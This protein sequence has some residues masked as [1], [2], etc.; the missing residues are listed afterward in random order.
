MKAPWPIAISLTKGIPMYVLLGSNGNI[1]SKAAALLLAHGAEVRVVGRNAR[2]LAA[3]QTAGAQIA[4]GDIAD[5]NFLSRAFAGATA[6]YAM[7]PSD[8][9]VPDMGADQ[10]Q[11][12]AA[13]AGAVV[14]A[15]VKRIVSLS[16]IGAHL[17]VGSGPITGLHRQEQRLNALGDLDVLHLRPGYFYENHLVAIEMIRTMGSYAD[18]TAPDVPLPMVATADI[19]QVVARELLTPSGKG[20]RVLHLRAPHLYTM[21][22]ATARLG[23]AVD[24]PELTYVQSD[25]QQGKAA[26]MQHGFSASAASLLEEMSAAFSTGI[27]N[28]EHEKGPTEA[29]QTTLEEFAV[30]VFKPAF[31]AGIR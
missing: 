7:I 26:L 13:I 15:G 11:M 30:T 2:S 16:S 9:T 8:Y 3:I 23:A 19:A 6:V 21:R 25:P 29:A 4:A 22:E 17:A 20:K 5:E 18:M 24:K 27:L 10:D 28:G 12:G 1:T 31:V 14:S